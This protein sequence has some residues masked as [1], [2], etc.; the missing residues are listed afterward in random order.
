MSA[1]CQHCINDMWGIQA[2][3][4]IVTERYLRSLLNLDELEQNPHIESLMRSL[5]K[6]VT[7]NRIYLTSS[8]PE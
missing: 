5:R 1:K 4:P 3:G 7:M 2:P 6:K 8:R